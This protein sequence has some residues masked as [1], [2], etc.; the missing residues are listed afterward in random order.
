[1]MTSQ[2]ARAT[3]RM[4]KYLGAKIEFNNRQSVVDCVVRNQSRSGAMLKIETA[5]E[6]PSVFD[7][8]IIKTGEHQKC[9]TVWDR[10]QAL[11]VRF[12]QGPKPDRRRFLRVVH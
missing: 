1:M 3:A 8:H 11:G 6:L 2:D 10:P 4:P 12:L 5:T 7:L 9:V